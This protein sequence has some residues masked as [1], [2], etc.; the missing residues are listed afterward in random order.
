M[1]YSYIKKAETKK[2]EFDNQ[3]LY[4]IKYSREADQVYIVIRIFNY[5]KNYYLKSI[6]NYII[7]NWSSEAS[8]VRNNVV[9]YWFLIRKPKFFKL[10]KSQFVK[11]KQLR[12]IGFC[13]LPDFKY[14]D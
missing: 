1:N 11:N 7:S 8:E 10:T 4:G 14:Y 5:N 2:W 12:I 3:T 9:M 6:H 13:N